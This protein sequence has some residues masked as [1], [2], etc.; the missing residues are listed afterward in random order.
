M[1]LAVEVGGLASPGEP[2]TAAVPAGACGPPL[3]RT[4]GKKPLAASRTVGAGAWLVLVAGEDVVDGLAA[5]QQA[6]ASIVDGDQGG[7]GTRL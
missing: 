6:W 7:R 5:D 4:G 1:G 3:T 2:P